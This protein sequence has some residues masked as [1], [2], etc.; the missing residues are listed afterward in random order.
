[1][2]TATSTEPTFSN[3]SVM[4][5]PPAGLSDW[6]TNYGPGASAAV[7][8]VP[9]PSSLLLLLLGSSLLTRVRRRS[10]RSIIDI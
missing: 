6:Q 1:M 10:C 9:E 5:A 7:S 3:G 4:M 8:T 2:E